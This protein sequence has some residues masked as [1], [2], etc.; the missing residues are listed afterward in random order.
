MTRS[1]ERERE[2]FKGLECNLVKFKLDV[3]GN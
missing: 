2:Y 1:R 3:L